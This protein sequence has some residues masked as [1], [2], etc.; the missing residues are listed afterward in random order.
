MF[1]VLLSSLSPSPSLLPSPNIL[2]PAISPYLSMSTLFISSLCVLFFSSSPILPPFC[3]LSFLPLPLAPN[4]PPP[5]PAQV[6]LQL[7]A[8]LRPRTPDE[9]TPKELASRYKQREVVEL[10][11]W[12]ANNYPSPRT[13]TAEWLHK[14]TDRNVCKLNLMWVMCAQLNI[15]CLPTPPE[16]S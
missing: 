15:T 5:H 11:E 8:P 2:L 6:L 9:D 4:P 16:V 13:T 14:A 12:A 1:A 3:L 10:L 7:N